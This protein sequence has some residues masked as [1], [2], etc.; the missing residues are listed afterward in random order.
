LEQ[1][2]DHVDVVIGV[3]EDTPDLVSLQTLMSPHTKLTS[4]GEVVEGSPE[5]TGT[6]LI[7]DAKVEAAD[8][9]ARLM[10]SDV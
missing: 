6:S 8:V 9:L 4:R 10:Q 5:T 7:P 2:G 1:E 3:V